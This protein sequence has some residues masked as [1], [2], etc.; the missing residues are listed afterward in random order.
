[1]RRLRSALACCLL[2]AC[3][4]C[5]AAALG[6][7]P[8]LKTRWLAGSGGPLF[9]SA[10]SV[11]VSD[12]LVVVAGTFAAAM[13]IDLVDAQG[14]TQAISV[15]AQSERD[16]FVQAHDAASGQIFW[17]RPLHCGAG[18]VALFA[19]AA[20]GPSSD[21]GGPFVLGN[22]FSVHLCQAAGGGHTALLSR[23][24][25]DGVP[26]GE[27][28]GPASVLGPLLLSPLPRGE[29]GVLVAGACADAA[30]CAM[31]GRPLAE[32]RAGA[33]AAF[34]ARVDGRGAASDGGGAGAVRVL[35][36]AYDGRGGAAVHLAVEDC[37]ADLGGGGA[38]LASPRA[39][40]DALARLEIE[41]GDLQ[42]QGPPGSPEP[43]DSAR[44]AW[45][46]PVRS[47][48][49]NSSARFSFAHDEVGNL[50][51]G[52]IARLA[53][54]PAALRPPGSG[55]GAA[56]GNAAVITL[57]CFSDAG[58][59]A[60]FAL[61][62]ARTVDLALFSPGETSLAF[63]PSLRVVVAAAPF[64]PRAPA[65]PRSAFTLVAAFSLEGAVLWRAGGPD[66]TPGS[67]SAYVLFSLA[68]PSD[69]GPEDVCAVFGAGGYG[70]GLCPGGGCDGSAAFDPL[71]VLPFDTESKE[72]APGGYAPGADVDAFVAALQRRC[73]A[74]LLAACA[75]DRFQPICA[76]CDAARGG[77]AGGAGGS[78]SGGA[79]SGPWRGRGALG[80][81]G[82]GAAAARLDRHRPRPRRFG[83]YL[84]IALRTRWA[85]AQAPPDRTVYRYHPGGRLNRLRYF[86]VGA[87]LE[88]D[89]SASE[90]EGSESSDEDD[91]EGLAGR[92]GGGPGRPARVPLRPMGPAACPFQR[93]PKLPLALRS[94][95]EGSAGIL[96]PSRP[97]P[98]SPSMALRSTLYET[99]FR[100]RAAAV[101]VYEEREGFERSEEG[102]N[103]LRALALRG[104]AAMAL[105]HPSLLPVLALY[106]SRCPFRPR[107]R[108]LVQVTAYA[109][110]TLEAW[111]RRLA[112]A[113]PPDMHE[114]LLRL[115]GGLASALSH[116]HFFLHPHRAFGGFPPGR[117]LVVDGAACMLAPY[118]ELILA[119]HPAFEEAR[120]RDVR[121]Y[122]RVLGLLVA[123]LETHHADLAEQLRA[124][125]AACCSEAEVPPSSRQMARAFEEALRGGTPTRAALPPSD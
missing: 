5:P 95:L 118:G 37:E 73:E 27:T 16:G 22:V 46:L 104:G 34:L 122:G 41:F 53:D 107:A 20:M 12:G 119:G 35:A 101:K 100:G 74:D 96:R 66:P 79:A 24:S 56:D 110:E 91:E 105:S 92:P 9:D 38:A 71:A 62:P 32:P 64:F 47:R 65:G 28:Q 113:P 36:V 83:V 111:A 117:V 120:V 19:T 97:S 78:G 57:S 11:S 39:A 77:L 10:S 123:P 108:R 61:D 98:S 3:M 7:V 29:P 63:S 44:L 51:V 106:R 59:P 76:C 42:G 102:T 75:A 99:T 67:G 6:P 115:A 30:R 80:A 18:G 109:P 50:F 2:M 93:L 4:C 88:D 81:V 15:E 58:Q 124:A 25:G 114:R 89:D 94:A 121:A 48:P 69:P 26:L 14:G 21:A 85:A 70:P 8:S 40:A 23:F 1:M 72:G 60:W 55:A 90:E 45:M 52:D 17:I 82:V 33:P 49:L 125:A 54:V 43:S 86:A 68:V 84:G 103:E 87:S 112:A 13:R 116:L 31:G